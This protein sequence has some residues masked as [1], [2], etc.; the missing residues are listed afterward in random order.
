MSVHI[1]LYSNGEPYD[2]T[3]RLTIESI[4][5]FTSKNVIIHDYNLER[6]KNS[7]W[8]PFIKDFPLMDRL[9]RRD[10][11]YCMYKVFC[12]WEVYQFMQDNDILYYVDSSQYFV[13][14]FT[15]NID[16]LCDICFE[17]GCIAGSVANNVVNESYG[18]CSD[19][20]IWKKVFPEIKKTDNEILNTMHILAAWV[21][22]KK[23]E[24]NT[25]FI[26]EWLYWCMY[27]DDEL[28]FPLVTYHHT[29]D[30][31][32]FNILVHK[33]KFLVFYNEQIP[34][35]YNKDKN[36]VL[37]VVNNFHNTQDHFIYL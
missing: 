33:Y 15:Q 18:C 31:S 11:Y 27:K 12:I 32:I 20:R 4:S 28:P 10:G 6:I 21:L 16:K 24:L 23:T 22:F 7:A 3:K 29:V 19:L 1:V 36:I 25:H 37:E 5:K 13:S 35:N 26:N 17:K 34:H 30:Q 2:T 9:G 14:G 8:F